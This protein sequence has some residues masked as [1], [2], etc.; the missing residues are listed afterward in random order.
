MAN[1]QEFI[2]EDNIF[3]NLKSE[4]KEDLL[5]EMVHLICEVENMTSQEESLAK[6]ILERE[7]LETTGIGRAFAI[8]HCRFDGFDTLKVFVGFPEFPVEF[9]SIDGDK[10]RVVFMIISDNENNELYLKVLSRLMYLLRN[11]ETR[12][13][14]ISISNKDQFFDVIEKSVKAMNYIPFAGL[15]HIIELLKLEEEIETYTKESEITKNAGVLAF[16]GDNHI[17]KL[18]SERN[19]LIHKIDKRLYGIYKQLSSKYGQEIISRIKKNIC[20]QCN[21]QLP[22]HILREMNR[23][24]QIIQCPTCSKIIIRSI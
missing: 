22:I 18:Q 12:E 7:K 13:K 21:V 3:F 1:I 2:N 17:Q 23:Q 5:K 16:E 11:S 20:E 4:V 24:N 14:L 10:V 8:P 19:E 6:G 9:Q 15:E